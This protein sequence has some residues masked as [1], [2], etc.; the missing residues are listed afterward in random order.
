V[1][2][3]GVVVRNGLVGL[4]VAA[5]AWRERVCL[6]AQAVVGLAAHHCKQ[7][8]HPTHRVQLKAH[9][10]GLPLGNRIAGA[11]RVRG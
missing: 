6:G 5:A 11:A 4:R 2:A 8:K 3:V 9:T 7:L 1:C 10:V